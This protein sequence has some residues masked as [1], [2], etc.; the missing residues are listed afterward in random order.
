MKQQN[1]KVQWLGVNNLTVQFFKIILAGS[2]L[3]FDD[4]SVRSREIRNSSRVEL[5]V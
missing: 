3:V 1:M 2:N 5:A 4:Q